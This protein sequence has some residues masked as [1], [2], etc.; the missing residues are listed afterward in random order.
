[1]APEAPAAS[2]AAATVSTQRVSFVLFDRVVRFEGGQGGRD[3]RRVDAAPRAP[4]L[5]VGD[6]ALQGALL[7]RDGVVGAG[8]VRRVGAQ[9]VGPGRAHRPRR[10]GC[11]FGPG[12]GRDLVGLW[13]WYL[14][15][16]CGGL[17][18]VGHPVPALLEDV[19]LVLPVGPLLRLL[20]PLTLGLGGLLQ[21]LHLGCEVIQRR[22]DIRAVRRGCFR[23]RVEHVRVMTL[24]IRRRRH[25]PPRPRGGLPRQGGR[26]GRRRRLQS[27]GRGVIER[28]RL[29]IGSQLARV[30]GHDTILP[31][32]VQTGQH[33]GR[34]ATPHRR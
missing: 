17:V 5:E 25:R 13:E 12:C 30:L 26:Q 14:G 31:T 32:Q 8:H 16:S 11:G 34:A 2:N 1:M 27:V 20:P 23:V 28:H 21:R 15:G 18:A 24:E 9:V 22:R 33:R 29:V 4:R 19:L 7:G 10:A 6:G 3:P